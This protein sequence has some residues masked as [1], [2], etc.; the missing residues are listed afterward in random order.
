MFDMKIAHVTA[1]RLEEE[2]RRRS[3]KILVLVPRLWPR[4]R[5][6]QQLQVSAIISRQ[7][8]REEL[9]EHREDILRE[10]ASLAAKIRNPKGPDASKWRG[11]EA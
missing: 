5:A 10:R 11:E 8:R 9:L 1:T 7:R 4:S 6:V 3:G 2:K